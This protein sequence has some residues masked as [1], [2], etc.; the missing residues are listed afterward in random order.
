MLA[1]A[2]VIEKTWDDDRLRRD[3]L[4]HLQQAMKEKKV[5]ACLFTT[6][7]SGL[8]AINTRIPQGHVFVPV[9]GNPVAFVRPMDDGYVSMNDVETRLPI[10]LGHP[11]DPDQESKLTR[12]AAALDDLMVECG[13]GG[14]SL[15]IDTIDPVGAVALSQHG[16]K[17]ENARGVLQAAAAVKTQDEILIYWQTGKIYDRIMRQF[18]DEMKPGIS[19]REMISYIY[20]QVVSMGGEGL[21]QINVCSG[22]NTW[23]W[24]RWPTERRFENGDLVG[25]DL[26]VYG[27]GGY[28]FDASRTYLCGGPGNDTQRELYKRAVEYNNACIDMLRPGLSI[29]EYIETIPKVP[30]KYEEAVY[31]FHIIHSNGLTPGEYPNVEKRHKVMEDTFKENQILSLDCYFG[32]SGYHE[33]V[34]L[35][36]LVLLTKDGAAKMADMP[37]EDRLL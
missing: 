8:Y 25:M 35:E 33:A 28:V 12:W 9:E 30:K 26:H 24:L 29:P 18:R 17:L 27:P 11:S 21:L 5:G 20:G 1:S 2:N 15:A 22:P 6:W 34:K 16:F 32:E 37:Y 36:E 19:E 10:Y 3:R 4:A 23:P 31:A 14:E 13:V 7:V